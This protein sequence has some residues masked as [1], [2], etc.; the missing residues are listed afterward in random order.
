MQRLYNIMT[1]FYGLPT[2]S[3]ENKNL[4]LEF[5]ANAGPRLVRL[6]AFGSKE[7]LLA[8]VPT[9]K[10]PTAH[11]DFF[12][13]GGHR[14]W[15]APESLARTY[16]PDND[17]LV[18]QELAEGVRLTQ[19]AEPETGIT[20]SVEIHLD[21][22]HPIVTLIH[23]LQNDG[24]ESVELAPW[25]ITQLKLGGVA[26]LPQQ[27]KPLDKDGLLPN[28]SL[29]LWTYTRLHDSRLELRDEYIAIHARPELPPCKVGYLNREGW[30]AYQL[31]DVLFI[32]RFQPIV[33]ATHP[34]FNCN[35]EVYCGDKFIE[36]ET[37]AP[38]VCLAPGQAAT[39]QEVWEV[40]RVGE[41]SVEELIRLTK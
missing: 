40:R 19:P 6:F 33:E 15:H 11:G 18:V 16:M 12:F 31:N 24:A 37:L 10:H 1:P 20:K 4:R 30:L 23:T 25:A 32:K 38:L 41:E 9:L 35:A 17:R 5:L 8:E 7:N 36:L 27:R 22:E 29:A 26:I 34:D 14:L 13:R 3:I 2:R 28:R 39:H 21:P